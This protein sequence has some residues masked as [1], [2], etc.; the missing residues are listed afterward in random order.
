MEKAD[1]ELL[2]KVLTIHNDPDR[3]DSHPEWSGDDSVRIDKLIRHGYLDEAAFTSTQ[4]IGDKGPR[5]RQIE[6]TYPLTTKGEG[7]L[8]R[9]SYDRVRERIAKTI[10]ARFTKDVMP[11]LSFGLSLIATV[12]SIYLALKLL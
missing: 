2:E 5:Y 11:G 8:S 6:T 9:D 12:L 7:E 1:R 3:A 4:V 10:F